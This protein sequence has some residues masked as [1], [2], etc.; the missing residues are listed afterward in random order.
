MPTQEYRLLKPEAYKAIKKQIVTGGTIGG[1]IILGILSV[2]Y[3][4]D[5]NNTSAQMEN[6]AVFTG[7]FTFIFPI[8][9]YTTLRRHRRRINDFV[10]VI[11]E[12]NL[13]FNPSQPDEIVLSFLEI[14]SVQKM[15][16]GTF[17]VCHGPKN[18]IYTI[19]AEIEHRDKLE[20]QLNTI[21]PVQDNTGSS[22]YLR[23]LKIVGVAATAMLVVFIWSGNKVTIAITGLLLIAAFGWLLKN[24]RALNGTT[25]GITRVRIYLLFV[26]LAIISKMVWVIAVK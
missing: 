11:D 7:L 19:P 2:V 16:N 12:H 13:T 18:T 21:T 5:P 17:L 10:L 4:P 3:L 6:I 23:Y 9:L 22:T 26:I 1:L 25:S 24:I 20:A 8:V 14:S 15:E